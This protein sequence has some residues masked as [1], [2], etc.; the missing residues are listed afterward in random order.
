MIP[1]VHIHRQAA[2]DNVKEHIVEKDYVLTWFLLALSELPE[3]RDFLR[4]K[5]G[6]CL[7]KMY[8]FH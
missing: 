1:P 5:G 3:V 4:F 6:T 8:Y 2:K 7:R